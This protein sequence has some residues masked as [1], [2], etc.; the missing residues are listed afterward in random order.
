[1]DSFSSLR[2]NLM[3]VFRKFS[4]KKLNPIVVMQWLRTQL[5]SKYSN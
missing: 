4:A 5:T 2:N 3:T 1:M